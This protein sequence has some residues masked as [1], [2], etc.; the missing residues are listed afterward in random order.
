LGSILGISAIIGLFYGFWL[1]GTL[2]GIARQSAKSLEE[3][4]AQTSNLEGLLTQFYTFT[5]LGI[6][7]LGLFLPKIKPTGSM[8]ETFWGPIVAIAGFIIVIWISVVTNLR[9]IHADIAFKM[10]EPFAGNQQWIVAN[11][12]YRRAIELSPDEDYYYLFLGRGSLEEAKTL[13]D[14]VQQEQAFKTAEADLIRAQTIN[15]LNPDHTANLARLYSWWALQAPDENTRLERGEISNQYYSRVTVLSPNNARLWDEWAILHLN[16]LNDPNKAHEL[17]SHSLEID[18][19]YDW[20]H[21]LIGDYYSKI[22]LD[23]EN[24]DERAQ[25]FEEAINHYQQAILLS[26][27][28]TNYYYALASAYQSL[29]NIEMVIS[30]LEEALAHA[31][32]SETWKIEDNL[33]HYYYQLDDVGNALIHAQKA[34]ETAP[35]TEQER[36]QTIISQLQELLSQGK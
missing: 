30:T 7:V 12:L 28:S 21:A 11:A 16:V 9:V 27:D 32:P 5:I 1:S 19:K 35:E 31:G 23:T 18:P 34:L 8:K 13:T 33:T 17:L 6:L 25:I 3:V 24:Q 29:N 14:P 2:A 4:I 20:T 36:I 15:P 22:A 10:A 26:P